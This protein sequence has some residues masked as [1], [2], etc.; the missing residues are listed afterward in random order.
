M[1]IRSN[2]LP[3]IRFPSPGTQVAQV[4]QRGWHTLDPQAEAIF[5]FLACFIQ[6]RTIWTKNDHFDLTVCCN[7]KQKHVSAVQGVERLLK[8]FL[9]RFTYVFEPTSGPNL[10]PRSRGTHTHTLVV[11]WRNS[12][13]LKKRQSTSQGTC[14]FQAKRS[15][16][17][18]FEPCYVYLGS[19]WTDEQGSSWE[20]SEVFGPCRAYVLL[21]V[22]PCRCHSFPSPH[23]YVHGRE[24]W[25]VCVHAC[26][27]IL[28]AFFSKHTDA[29]AV[30]YADSEPHMSYVDRSKQSW[31]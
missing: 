13:Y 23:A 24:C 20:V 31:S 29:P 12:W 22:E 10:K 11:R 15:W 25:C 18:H 8:P 2:A 26:K 21:S 3:A 19:E 7:C 17:A 28:Y 27:D 1:Q 30:K 16:F 9:P 14:I 4:W 6:L 5:V